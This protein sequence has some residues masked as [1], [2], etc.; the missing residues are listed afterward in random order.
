MALEIIPLLL[1][2]FGLGMMHALDADH[3]MAVSALSNERPSARRAMMHSSHW[4]LGHGGMLVVCGL[5]LFGIG[6]AIPEGLQTFAEASVGVLLIVLGGQCFYQLR[7]EK[8]VLTSH[9]HGDVTHVHWTRTDEQHSS[10]N[11]AT[12]KGKNSETSARHKPVFVGL[13]HGLAGSAPA[14]ALIP[15]VSEGQLLE[16]LAYLVIFSL[17]VMIAM[18]CFGLGF[19]QFQRFL[20]AR[21]QSIFVYSRQAVACVS[22]AF[23]GY[24]IAQAI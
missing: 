12:S 24:W 18:V 6:V 15:V 19:G 8:V 1:V 5:M 14:L 9:S 16:A 7:R 13:L 20:S 22:I 10:K 2:G 23:G 3:I 11:E 17:G 4:A 21:Y